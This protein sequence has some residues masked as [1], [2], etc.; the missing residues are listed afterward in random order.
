MWRYGKI[1]FIREGMIITK[2]LAIG[3]S[4]ITVVILFLTSFTNVVG[5]QTVQS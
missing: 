4:L 3:L 5:Y 1:Q 2:V